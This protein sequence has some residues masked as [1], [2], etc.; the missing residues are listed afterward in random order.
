MNA[1]IRHGPCVDCGAPVT[2]RDGGD[3][4]PLLCLECF[5]AD[6]PNPLAVLFSIVLLIVGA[7]VVAWAVVP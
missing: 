2:I 3:D 6:R 1:P 4:A 7:V 5:N